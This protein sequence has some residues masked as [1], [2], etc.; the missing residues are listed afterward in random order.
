MKLDLFWYVEKEMRWL[1]IKTRTHK[2]AWIQ[3][4]D[5]IPAELHRQMS[6]PSCRDKDDCSTRL[7]SDQ[8]TRPG[9]PHVRIVWHSSILFFSTCHARDDPFRCIHVHQFHERSR[10]KEIET[11][12]G[13][14][15]YPLHR[16]SAQQDLVHPLLSSPAGLTAAQQV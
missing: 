10:R 13:S 9:G 1:G 14:I 5:K 12:G 2:K 4:H 8:L 15:D 11:K 6:F 3:M 7:A 16:S